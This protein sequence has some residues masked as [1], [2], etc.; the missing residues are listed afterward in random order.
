MAQL[1]LCWAIHSTNIRQYSILIVTVKHGGYFS[2]VEHV[3]SFVF[4]RRGVEFASGEPLADLVAGA[5]DVHFGEVSCDFDWFSGVFELPEFVVACGFDGLD[6]ALPFAVWTCPFVGLW[7]AG[8]L[9]AALWAGADDDHGFVWRQCL[10]V[11]S[12]DVFQGG[13]V[14]GCG[15]HV[16][17]GVFV[18]EQHGPCFAPAVSCVC[19]SDFA[20][21]FG[22]PRF[23]VGDKG[24]RVRVDWQWRVAF[25]WRV[26]CWA[27][28]RLTEHDASQ[29]WELDVSELADQLPVVFSAAGAE[30]IC[31][32]RLHGLPAVLAVGQ[33]R[34][35]LSYWWMMAA[36]AALGTCGTSGAISSSVYPARYHLMIMF[37]SIFFICLLL[38]WVF[39]CIWREVAFMVFPTGGIAFAPCLAAFVPC[40]AA[41]VFQ[42]FQ[43]VHGFRF[44][45]TVLEDVDVR[46]V[47]LVEHVLAFAN[48][49][50]QS[51]GLQEVLVA[52]A[53]LIVV[54][55]LRPVSAEVDDFLQCFVFFSYVRSH[56][57]PPC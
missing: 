50:Q 52:I 51:I 42:P 2:E 37:S 32:H 30:Q 29:G 35:S 18:A 1:L 53:F 33:S 9:V 56:R 15:A 8:G 39:A 14:V 5:V 13:V 10:F 6:S 38:V 34:A 47:R 7:C 49:T 48:H 31:G 26:A 21:L 22:E 16:E 3:L 55:R 41:F 40:L 54:K 57:F 11:A 36:T 24:L 28:V 43:D 17:D 19:G 23:G 12:G 4:C 27:D 45:I 20:C 25:A 46:G 44:V